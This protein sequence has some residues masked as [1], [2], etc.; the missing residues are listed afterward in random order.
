MDVTIHGQNVKV[1]DSI[2]AYARRKLNRLDRYLPGIREIRL[3]LSHNNSKRGGATNTA[4][5][6]VRHQ[7]GA[8]LRT[9]E[10]DSADFES[11]INVVVDKMYRRIRR[12]KGKRIDRNRQPYRFGLSPEEL[13]AAEEMPEV[14]LPPEA[15]AGEE[16]DEAAIAEVVRRKEVEVTAM[17]DEEAIEQMELL[18]HDFF[19][20]FNEG[21]GNFNVVYR[22]AS[23]GY[24]VLVPRVQ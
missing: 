5:L 17:T 18:G 24:G 15:V 6:T 19:V 7:R 8:I 9:E 23:G 10:R 4:Q 20:Y 13:S 2:D 11:A 16:T 22:R 21:T 14:D 1:S 12:F 3:D